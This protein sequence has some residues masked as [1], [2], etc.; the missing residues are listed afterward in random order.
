MNNDIRPIPGSPQERLCRSAVREVGFGGQ[1]GGA[2][3]FG[4]ILDA[5]YQLN[6]PGYDAILFRRTYKQLKEAGGLI[7][8]SREV[9]P[10]LG[11][12]FNESSYAWKFP[13]GNTIRFSYL[14]REA[15]I[16][17]HSGSQY[18][19][20]AFD[21]LQNF[22]ERQY[23]FLFSRNR[24]ANPDI[25]LYIRSTFNPGGTGHFWIKKRFIEPFLGGNGKPK[26]FKRADGRDI[27]TTRDDPYAIS[28]LFI[29]SRLED[30]PYLWRGGDSEYERNLYQ[31]DT[32]DFRRLRFGDW[33]IRRTGR[34]YHAFGSENIGPAS[35]ELDTSR[36]EG[37]YHSHDFGAVNHVW[38]LWAKIG[39][40]YFLMYE[41]KLAEGT[42]EAR[43]KS[44]ITRFGSRQIV[45]GWGGAAS[46]KQYRLDFQNHGVSIRQP[47]VM[48]RTPEDE[49][50][51]SQIRIANQM[52][53]NREMM[54]CSD[55]VFTIDQLENCVRDDNG[56]IANKSSW[57]YLDGCI[58][59]FAAGITRKGWGR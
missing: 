45:A 3:S 50:V 14:E 7:D 59:Y 13:N 11:G 43:A 31:L 39:K 19:Y 54:I 1:A 22:S 28:R 35:Y 52:F 51:E 38:G 2:K 37:Y 8:L 27:E 57:H 32:V 23:L 44:I 16:E 4:L 20:I 12:Q 6:K 30:N 10:K 34:V 49:I 17:Q 56:K 26:Y 5:C 41:E 55:M 9:Y 15:D 18:A 48:L 47:G 36:I 25:N 53:G 40:Q 33:D 21:E 29:A 58:R 24:S 42:T 46:E